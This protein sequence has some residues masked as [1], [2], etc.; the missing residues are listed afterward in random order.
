MTKSPSVG[1]KNKSF[2]DSPT[3]EGIM[4]P[5]FW[6]VKPKP[7]KH[8]RD[9]EIN[10]GGKCDCGVDYLSLPKE[11]KKEEIKIVA[12]QMKKVVDLTKHLP[13]VPHI[14]TIVDLL[15]QAEIYRTVIVDYNDTRYKIT[16]I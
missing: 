14:K 5:L 8:W 12:V 2:Y 10:N 13:T 1:K 11:K 4:E 7:I 3:L 6:K 9:C 15:N 16:K